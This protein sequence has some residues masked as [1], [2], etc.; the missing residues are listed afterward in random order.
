VVVNLPQLQTRPRRSFS[1]IP[2]RRT[3]RSTFKFVRLS[4]NSGAQVNSC[5]W[6]A[7]TS[8]SGGY[9][10]V[11]QGA[12]GAVRDSCAAS[13]EK[14]ERLEVGMSRQGLNLFRP[15][16]C[17]LAPAPEPA[18][19]KDIEAGAPRLCANRSKTMRGFPASDVASAIAASNLVLRANRARPANPKRAAEGEDP[20][21]RND[22]LG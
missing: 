3:T 22:P 6:S 2:G 15:M 10:P 20:K 5:C 4:A 8:N 12:P 17:L 18:G 1:T 14:E 19:E 21:R 7:G 11:P 9:C 16:G 13:G